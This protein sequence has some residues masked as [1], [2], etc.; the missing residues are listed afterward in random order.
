MYSMSWLKPWRFV[1]LFLLLL[2]TG[3]SGSY[4]KAKVKGWVKFD[5]KLVPYGKVSFISKAGNVEGTGDIDTDG[6]Y[7]VPNAPVGEVTITVTTPPSGRP[8]GP[9][10]E[11]DLAKP[12]GTMGPMRPPGSADPKATAAN[13]D[14]SKIVAIPLKY[15][16]VESSGL[17][18]TVERG[19][20]TK[21]II[22]S[23]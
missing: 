23:P 13:F 19:E 12:P 2:V 3:C 21:N 5:G 15:G 8:G 6:T 17:K 22:L 18:Y 10:G 16:S 1:L 7:E 20:Q 11:N 4:P 14:A 9:G